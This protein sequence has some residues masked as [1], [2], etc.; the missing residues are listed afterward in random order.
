VLA[1]LRLQMA[2][3]LLHGNM[4]LTDIGH[5]CGFSDHSAFARHFKQAVG[6]TPREYRTLVDT[7]QCPSQTV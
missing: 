3:H 1:K 6:M 4:R 7:R 2:M 5:A